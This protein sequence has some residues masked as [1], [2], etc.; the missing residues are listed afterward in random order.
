[1]KR[2]PNMKNFLSCPVKAPDGKLL[3]KTREKTPLSCLNNKNNKKTLA[4]RK[5]SEESACF[6]LS[7]FLQRLKLASVSIFHSYKP[8]RWRQVIQ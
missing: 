5:A 2:C 6:L 3:L 8:Q 7:F 1:M 4:W